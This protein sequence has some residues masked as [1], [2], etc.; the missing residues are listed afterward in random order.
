[1]TSFQYARESAIQLRN[2]LLGENG[3]TICSYEHLLELALEH[4]DIDL[5]DVLS[6]DPA[7]HEADAIYN[8]DLG[9][10][11]IR[12]DVNAGERAFLVAHELGHVDLHGGEETQCQHIVN[13]EVDPSSGDSF[14]LQRV[15][16]Y[17]A[18]ERTELQANVYG[19]EFLFPRSMARTLF[20]EGRSELDIVD[21]TKLPPE[22]VRLQLLDALLL[23]NVEATEKNSRPSVIPSPEQQDAICSDAKTS[24][25]VAGPG[26]GKTETLL[27][28]IQHLTNIGVAPHEILVLTFSNRAAREL[29]ERLKAMSVGGSEQMWI[30]TFHAFG[31]EFLRKNHDKFGL[32]PVFRLAEKLD[33]VSLLEPHLAGLE[34]KYFNSFS[35][36]LSWLDTVV[37]AI[38]RAKDELAT[39]EIYLQHVEGEKGD[40]TLD[41]HN[42]R[43]DVA[44]LYALYESEKQRHGKFVDMGD[45]IMLPTLAL[46]KNTMDFLSTIGTFQH[47]LVDEYQDVNRA[48]ARLIKALSEQA[49]S[50]WVVGDPRQAIYR[51]RGA[52]M[53]NV[54]QFEKDFPS[55]RRYSLTENRRSDEEIVRL[56]E[57]TGKNHPLQYMLPLDDV[58]TVKG[59]GGA[60]PTL[61]TCETNRATLNAL[62]QTVNQHSNEG[63][64]YSEQAILASTHKACGEAANVLNSR[65]IPAL[66][67]GDIFEREEI[68]DL[69]SLLHL[70]LDRSA[71]ALIRVSQVEKYDL[72]KEDLKVI[73][74]YLRDARPEI[75]SWITDTPELSA[76]GKNSLEN[77]LRAYEGIKSSDNPWD[78]LCK[79][80]L[81]SPRLLDRYLQGDDIPTITRRIAIWQFLH[82]CRTPGALGYAHNVGSFFSTLRRRR[83]LRDD[84]ELRIPPPE[85]DLLNA[86]SVLT[87]HSSKGLEYESVHFMDVQSYWFDVADTNPPLLPDSLVGQIDEDQDDLESR[88]EGANKLYVALSRA[89]QYLSMYQNTSVWNYAPVSALES[90]VHFV[91][92]IFVRDADAVFSLPSQKKCMPG[93]SL[94]TVTHEQF[95]VY[96]NCARQFYYE[97]VLNLTPVSGRHIASGIGSAV[98]K[99]LIIPVGSQQNSQFLD[100]K[101]E[102]IKSEF[103][104]A[105]HYYQQYAEKLLLQGRHWLGVHAVYEPE[106]IEITC[107]HFRFQF[108]PHQIIQEGTSQLIFRLFTYSKIAE[109]SQRYKL[110]RWIARHLKGMWSE[111]SVSLQLANL[112]TGEIQQIAPYYRIDSVRLPVLANQLVSGDFSPCNRPQACLSCRHFTYCPA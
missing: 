45:L 53:K 79:L 3:D 97:S 80:L 60:K 91:D 19:R 68:K 4:H 72:S 16:A 50:L 67:L 55:A 43:V 74:N 54:V 70:L 1:M 94:P 109:K 106:P 102:I 46:E 7:L 44:A 58:Q 31:L 25:V 37:T 23:P 111:H 65:G 103:P 88:T 81:G 77:L 35:D 38:Q 63:I 34:L 101:L 66:Y 51:F 15:E 95:L 8:Q 71:S 20:T 17:G 36:P 104:D 105:F 30:G 62:V 107:D 73:I 22:L 26:T 27:Q 98:I 110:M 28:R 96:L 86:V 9:Q 87:I 5:V 42:R 108:V 85:A 112:D 56:F 13:S 52:S 83:R 32:P 99:S 40:V 89:K 33:Q 84:R 75:M 6:A 100:R 41:L 82:Y 48:S 69:L 14:A 39:P 11:L 18:R 47:I 10:I 76:Q 24:L 49:K 57:Q 12:N 61:L 21:L 93:I 29:L 59:E 78:V 90:A 2:Q 92:T 64:D